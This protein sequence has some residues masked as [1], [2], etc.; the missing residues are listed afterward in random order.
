[1]NNNPTAM[2][3]MNLAGAF[4]DGVI[5]ANQAQDDVNQRAILTTRQR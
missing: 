1:M 3:L 2:A 4:A 5:L